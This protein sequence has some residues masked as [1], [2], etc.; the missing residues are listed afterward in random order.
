MDSLI[1]HFESDRE[2]VEE[3]FNAIAD[4]FDGIIVS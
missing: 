1:K 2:E 4:S 3:I